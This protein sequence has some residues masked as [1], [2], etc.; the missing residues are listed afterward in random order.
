MHTIHN[1]PDEKVVNPTTVQ[2]G[3]IHGQALQLDSYVVKNF[4]DKLPKI[5]DF[6]LLQQSQKR[7]RF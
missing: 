4:F 6:G 2:C 5:T 3:W 7:A 1:P